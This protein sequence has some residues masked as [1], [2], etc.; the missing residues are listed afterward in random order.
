MTKALLALDVATTTGFAFGR[1]G[2]RPTVSGAIRFGATGACDEDV[3]FA[4]LK[5]ITDQINVLDPELVAIEAPIN[6]ANTHG[7]SSA[8]TLGRLLGL[9]AIL[10]T[11]VRARR[12]SLAKLVHVQSVRKTF[13]GHGNLPGPEAK[14]RVR[15]KCI[16]LGWVDEADASFDRCDALAVWAKAASDFDPSIKW[17]MTPLAQ[18]AE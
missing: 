5:W 13:I 9:Q 17:D 2:E 4:A 1:I 15:E 11:V 3:W 8:K 6:S 14:R 7:G 10:R 12:P 18:A 16:A